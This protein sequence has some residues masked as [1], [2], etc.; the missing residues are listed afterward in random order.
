MNVSPG[1]SGASDGAGTSAWAQAFEP[2][3]EIFAFPPPV[4]LV[5][6]F[7][8][9][10]LH[11]VGFECLHHLMVSPPLNLLSS[12]DKVPFVSPHTPQNFRAKSQ[13]QQLR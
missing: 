11:K 7:E 10:L 2:A 8:Q 1:G 4:R 13:K 12:N 5:K 9:I 3:P 6:Q